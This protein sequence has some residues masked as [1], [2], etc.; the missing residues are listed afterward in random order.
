MKT[1]VIL[2]LKKWQV[3]DLVTQSLQMMK[4]GGIDF[5]DLSH[6]EIAS[7]NIKTMILRSIVPVLWINA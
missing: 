7:S 3:N 1:S 2:S 5:Q 4:P 6:N